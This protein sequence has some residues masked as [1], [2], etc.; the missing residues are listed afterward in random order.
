MRFVEP[1]AGEF[2][3][4]IE[5]QIRLILV[6]AFLDRAGDEIRALRH[7]L[8][9]DL[10][11][12]GAAQQI[13]AAEAVIGHNLGRLHHL[14]LIG[15]DAVGRLQNRLEQRMRIGHRLFA[16]LAPDVARDAVHRSGP[17]ERIHRNNVFEPVGLELAQAVAHARAFQLEDTVR[18]ATGDQLVGLG[19]IE[20]YLREIE[21]RAARGDEIDRLRQHVEGLEAEEVE[22][23]QAGE[24]D[25]FH[26][27]LRHR[28]VGARIAVERHQLVERPVADHHAG[29][30]GRGVAIKAF[31]LQRD[32]H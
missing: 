16:V 29:R 7:H 22:L 1:V 24:L 21:R 17:I 31:E 3:H 2:L 14:F 13:G 27:E 10:L 26:A 23:H 18:L 25:I 32:L 8:G 20:G 30:V 15:E 12:H 9:F 19:V 11:A 6:D 4:Q 5:N 28:H